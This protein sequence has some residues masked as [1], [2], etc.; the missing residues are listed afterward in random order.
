MDELFFGYVYCLI[1]ETKLV[2]YTFKIFKCDVKFIINYLLHT[3][4]IIIIVIEIE[5]ISSI[6]Q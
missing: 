3:S 6:I 5:F 2:I 4:K 1:K